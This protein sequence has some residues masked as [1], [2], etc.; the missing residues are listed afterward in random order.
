MEISQLTPSHLC[1]D[2]T[3]KALITTY[4]KISEDSSAVKLQS[5]V[6]KNRGIPDLLGGTLPNE[7]ID[8]EI[9]NGPKLITG[10]YVMQKPLKKQIYL[11]Y[12]EI[13]KISPLGLD[14]TENDNDHSEEEVIENFFTIE[15]LTDVQF[16]TGKEIFDFLQKKAYA[17]GFKLCSKHRFAHGIRS[18]P[19][20]SRIKHSTK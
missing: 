1:T 5:V 2:V 4:S 11:P 20:T 18:G 3:I 16:S 8:S 9:Y 12:I 7:L 15:N 6:S 17:Q 19:R 13:I 10:K 14:E